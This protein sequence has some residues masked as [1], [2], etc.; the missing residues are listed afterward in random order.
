MPA[1]NST[2]AAPSSAP[3]PPPAISWSAPR[4]SPPPGRRAS[5]ARMPNGRTDAVRRA[6]PSI[7]AISARNDSM[8]GFGR[9]LLQTPWVR[10]S[11]CSLY[12][13]SWT[14]GVKRFRNVPVEATRPDHRPPER[15][16]RVARAYVTSDEATLEAVEEAPLRSAGAVAPLCGRRRPAVHLRLRQA[17]GSLVPYLDP[18]RRFRERLQLG[19][20][21]RCEVEL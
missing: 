16:T 14:L 8:A 9:T 12:V 4:A 18:E 11:N 7:L 17:D 13:L 15:D 10:L 1:T 21:R 19:D 5:T 3:F 20:G 6:R 2:A